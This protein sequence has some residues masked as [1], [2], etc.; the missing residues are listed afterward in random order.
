VDRSCISLMCYAGST[1]C[2]KQEISFLRSIFLK[3]SR[4]IFF[5][6]KLEVI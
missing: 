2:L 3:F 6:F 5:S 1:M 4:N